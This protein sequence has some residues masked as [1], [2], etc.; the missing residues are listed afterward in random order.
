MFMTS[1]PAL[2]MTPK[3]RECLFV[4]LMPFKQ[5]INL[6]SRQPIVFVF[7]GNSGG[8]WTFDGKPVRP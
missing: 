2:G 6:A 7:G 1:P 4:D 3:E 5:T 8:I